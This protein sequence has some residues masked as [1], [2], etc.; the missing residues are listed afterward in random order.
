MAKRQR[1]I[2]MG[3]EIPSEVSSL[4]NS[5]CTLVKTD[6]SVNFVKIISVENTRITVTNTRGARKN[7]PAGEIRE[8]IQDLHA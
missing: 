3:Q 1:R 6:N 4:I 2:Q 8:I 7:I 5:F